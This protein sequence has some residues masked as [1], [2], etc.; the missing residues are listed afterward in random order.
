MPLAP[1]AP[2]LA[3]IGPVEI[4][5]LGLVVIVLVFG[6]R[7]PE[8]AKRVGESFGQFQKSKRKVEEEVEGVSEDLDK[9]RE[10]VDSIKQETGIEEDIQYIKDDIDGVREPLKSPSDKQEPSTETSESEESNHTPSD[11]GANHETEPE[12]Q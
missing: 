4:M 10:E 3:F 1:V 5:L 2:T 11:D 9:V 7:A 6:S 8:V 12:T